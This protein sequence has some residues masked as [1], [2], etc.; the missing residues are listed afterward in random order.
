MIFQFEP[1]RSPVVPS[2]G[3]HRANALATDATVAQ[4]SRQTLERQI[5]KELEHPIHLTLQEASQGSRLILYVLL[6]SIAF[7]A[8]VLWE[9]VIS[10][11]IYEV[12]LPYPSMWWVPIVACMGFGLWASAALGESFTDF[13]LLNHNRDAAEREG[14]IDRARGDLYGMS[15]NKTVPGMGFHPAIGAFIAI[16]LLCVI[17]WFSWRRVEL[18]KELGHDP[19]LFQVYL[20][21]ILYVG[22]I[23]L[24]MPAFFVMAYWY[25][26]VRLKRLRAKLVQA[27]SSEDTL[28]RAAIQTYAEYLQQF[29]SYNAWAHQKQQPRVLLVPANV[30][31][32]RLLTQEWGYDPTQGVPEP[33]AVHGGPTFSIDGN[34]HGGPGVPGAGTSLR[35]KEAK[36]ET[37]FP[38]AATQP[39]ASNGS[40]EDD[41]TRLL[42]EQI[43]S[44]NSRF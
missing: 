16:G 10:R 12:V 20:P 31:L 23:A 26:T 40:R 37:P 28:R 24:G 34:G 17:G 14:A 36:E 42:D 44:Q 1:E 39:A 15:R 5:R 9:A 21:V 33:D 41:L 13:R 22:E 19:G 32:R 6:G 25:T 43:T 7:P 35:P 11:E 4:Q 38:E 2:E 3:A 27:K 18:L 30:E 29:D 8:V